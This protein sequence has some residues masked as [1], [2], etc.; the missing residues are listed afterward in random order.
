MI[1][2][3]RGSNSDILELLPSNSISNR[4]ILSGLLKLVFLLS[5]IDWIQWVKVITSYLAM[6]KCLLFLMV[7]VKCLEGCGICIKT[8]D[9][10][11]NFPSINP[12]YWNKL[13]LS[14]LYSP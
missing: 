11:S 14:L 1:R 12:L 13:S 7:F 6:L 4:K 8:L 2:W 3:F 5:K 9:I 10:F